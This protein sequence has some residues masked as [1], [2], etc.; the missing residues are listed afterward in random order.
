[1]EARGGKAWGEAAGE[2]RDK[3]GEGGRE[4]RRLNFSFFLK[5]AI[6]VMHQREN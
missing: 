2:G 5:F 3:A 4:G 6:A 1:M